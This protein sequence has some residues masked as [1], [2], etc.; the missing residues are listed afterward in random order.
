MYT[1]FTSTST[2]V[3]SDGSS[4]VL[5]LVGLAEL[6]RRLLLLL[7]LLPR[8]VLARA[9]APPL[10]PWVWG[11]RGERGLRMLARGE[12]TPPRR[13]R[14]LALAPLRPSASAS[15]SASTMNWYGCEATSG[16]PTLCSLTSASSRQIITTYR[17]DQT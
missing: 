10:R 17:P 5:G 3:H 11:E 1:L 13:E 4:N 8:S 9:W 16:E 14:G 12:S 7:L 2:Y 6:P 15:A